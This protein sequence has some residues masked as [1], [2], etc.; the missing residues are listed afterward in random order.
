MIPLTN[1]QLLNSRWI[2]AIAAFA[3]LLQGSAFDIAF[4]SSTPWLPSILSFSSLVLF[5]SILT[6]LPPRRGK[7]FGYIF[8]LSYL[9]WGLSWIYISMAQFGNAPL[10]FAIL[11]NIAVVAYLSLY[12]LAIGYL[13]PKIGRGI[14][15]RLLI[16]VPLIAF[17]E[18][19]R[20]VFLIG[21]PWLSIGYAWIDTPFAQLARFTGAFGLGFVIVLCASVALLHM[22][23]WY[24]LAY[25]V[26][27][28]SAIYVSTPPAN[29]TTS[30]EP[31]NVALIQGNMSVITRYDEERMDENLVQ[32]ERLT[33]QALQ[34]DKAID[35]LI[36]PESSIPY[37]YV[38]AKDFLR[39]IQSQYQ[40]PSTFDLIA[41]VPKFDVETNS[42]YNSLV[43]QK[44]NQTTNQFYYKHHLLPFG[45][46][47]PFRKL[48]S[49]FED[50]VTIPM[51]SFSF[52]DLQQ[53]GFETK[54]VTFS[55]SIC[56]EIVFGDEIR[57]NA[58]RASVLLNLSNEAWFGKSK[59]QRQHL[60]I[61]RMRAIENG[62]PLVRATNNGLTAIINES[63][64]VTQS[65]PPFQEGIL[66]AGV[67]PRHEQTFYARYG[68][69]PWVVMFIAFFVLILLLSGFLPP[70]C[71]SKEHSQEG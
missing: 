7:F 4:D 62:K 45:E 58:Q 53:R 21:F 52:G 65:L 41:A 44:H 64:S 36:W 56:F 39:S 18:W 16:A 12:W 24:K 2:Y 29:E 30:D 9:G 60:N 61:A 17:L 68:D 66:I 26:V 5:L 48:L 11:A 47:I 59:A 57:H 8:A 25:A 43:L 34:K 69:L 38:D 33:Q 37:Y 27:L 23:M 63:G 35:V 3:G 55:P 22:R 6:R 46:Y 14:N 71:K 67:I 13:V 40:Q 51:A 1:T 49:F 28:V 20:S 42:I 10:V 32:Y 15:Q 70:R 54:G 50:F 19:V 31:I